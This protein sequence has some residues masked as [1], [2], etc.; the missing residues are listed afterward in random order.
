MPWTADPNGGFTSPDVE[1]WLPFGD[2]SRNVAAQRG[3]PHS[4]LSLTRA[5]IA[6]RRDRDDLT[7]G[8]YTAVD[9]PEGIW[10]WR[11]GVATVVALNHTESPLEL[12][13]GGGEVLLST[14]R[15]RVGQGI[16]DR[17]RLEAWEAIVVSQQRAG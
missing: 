4:V 17:V 10:A 1:P 3:D 11:R 2:A 15:E 14:R 12:P 7:G 13:L 16:L 6:L 9:A 5:L 8:S